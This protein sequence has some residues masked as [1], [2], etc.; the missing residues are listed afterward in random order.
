MDADV[1]MDSTRGENQTQSETGKR[2]RAKMSEEAESPPTSLTA[3]DSEH[4]SGDLEDAEEYR[5]ELGRRG[6]SKSK[7]VPVVER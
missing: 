2:K 3:E 1:D 6:R 7:S 5:D 4:S